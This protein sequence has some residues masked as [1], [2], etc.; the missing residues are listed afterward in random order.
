M[1]V[2]YRPIVRSFKR[3]YTKEAAAHVRAGGHAIV[4]ENDKRAVLLFQ[5]PPKDVPEDYGAWSAA[6]GVNVYFFGNN[7][8]KLNNEDEVWVVGTWGVSMAY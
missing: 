5:T 3:K 1:S 6:G 7:T 2:T 4:W 8:R